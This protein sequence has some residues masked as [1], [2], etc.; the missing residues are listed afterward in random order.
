MIKI[1]RSTDK[2]WYFVVTAK[3]GKVLVTSET[4][5]SKR[6]LEKGIAS[7]KKVMA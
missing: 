1:K 5:K 6:N 7:L 3:N 4:Y 2:Q